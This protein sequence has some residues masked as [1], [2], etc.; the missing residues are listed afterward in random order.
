MP[1]D[2]YNFASA[3]CD[4][5]LIIFGGMRGNYK[6]TQNLYR[7]QLSDKRTT[8]EQPQSVESGPNF[9]DLNKFDDDWPPQTPPQADRADP[10]SMSQAMSNTINL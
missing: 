7:I 8:Y 10:G 1:P 5:E 2:L 4:D 9:E 3:I 6:Q